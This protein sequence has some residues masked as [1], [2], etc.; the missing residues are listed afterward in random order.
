[1]QN[2]SDDGKKQEGAEA[3][4]E[5]RTIPQRPLAESQHAALLSSGSVP[6]G[7]TLRLVQVV[8]TVTEDMRQVMWEMIFWLE[9]VMS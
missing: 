8:V 2:E 6:A 1:M 4:P 5:T 3:A 7:S 9:L